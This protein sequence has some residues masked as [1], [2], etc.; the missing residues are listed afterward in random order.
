VTNYDTVRKLRELADRMAGMPLAARDQAFRDSFMAISDRL[1]PSLEAASALLETDMRRLD[2]A[3]EDLLLAK[4][5]AWVAR[6]VTGE[7]MLILTRAVMAHRGLSPAELASTHVNEGRM[8][9]AWSLVRGI[10]ASATAPADPG[11][12]SLQPR[13]V[14]HR[15]FRLPPRRSTRYRPVAIRRSRSTPGRATSRPPRSRSRAWRSPLW[16]S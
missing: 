2:P 15:P 3:I 9:N 10:A 1:R 11:A 13:G 8:A 16:T 4:N 14:F 7:N 5:M 6:S 12:R